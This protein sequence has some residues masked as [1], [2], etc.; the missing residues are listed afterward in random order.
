MTLSQAGHQTLECWVDVQGLLMVH[1]DDCVAIC[2]TKGQEIEFINYSPHTIAAAHLS[3][4]L[5]LKAKCRPSAG[6]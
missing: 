1:Q 5:W 6:M 3:K 4:W 2:I